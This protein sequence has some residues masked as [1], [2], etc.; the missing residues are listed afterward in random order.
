MEEPIYFVD[1]LRDPTVDEE[2]GETIEAHP[3]NYEAIPGGL[4]DIKLR[5]EALQRRFNEESKVRSM[6]RHCCLRPTTLQPYNL[7]WQKGS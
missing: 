2:T 4:P 3:S 1:F 7:Y 6:G 5:V